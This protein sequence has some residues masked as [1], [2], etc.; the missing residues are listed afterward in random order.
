MRY[1]SVEWNLPGAT[2]PEHFERCREAP[3]R[4]PDAAMNDSAVNSLS[5]GP[6]DATVETDVDGKSNSGVQTRPKVEFIAGARPHLASETTSILR[7]RL[8][9]AAVMLLI[10]T[11][12]FLARTLLSS[13]PTVVGGSF[14]IGYRVFVLIMLLLANALLWSKLKLNLS[15]LRAIELA[16]FGL[17]CVLFLLLNYGMLL[18]LGDDFRPATTGDVLTPDRIRL[19]V[20]STTFMWFAMVIIYGTFIPNTVR[21]AAGVI[22]T[23]CLAPLAVII[24]TG[25]E[26]D[27]VGRIVFPDNLSVATAG[28]SFAFITALYGSYKVSSLRREA[29]EARRLGQY[30][31]TERLGAG[32]MGEVYLAEHQLLKRPCAIKLIRAVDAANAKALARFEREVRAIARLT[33]WNSVEIFD[34]GQTDDGTFYYAMEYLPGLSLQEVIER[35]GPLQPARAVHLLRQVCQA[36]NEAHT[37]GLIH[38]DIKPSNIIASQR[39]GVCDVAKLVDFGLATSVED[40]QEVKLTQEG[41]IAG[42]PFYIAPERFLEDD[43]PDARSDIY[44]L[45]GVAYFLLTGQPPF[46]GDVPLQIMIAHAREPVVPPRQIVADVPQDLEEIIVKCLAKEPHQRYADAAALEKALSECACADCWSQE[47]AAK[48]WVAR[49]ESAGVDTQADLPTTT[50]S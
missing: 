20:L 28:M 23:M 41:T 46:R 37:A 29:F 11:L 26:N 19:A 16:V 10:P 4:G 17:P 42:S 44:S 13:D 34:Y 6:L 27:D 25:L 1:D 50:L 5:G 33:H 45:G 2:A 9:I 38:R 21:R 35:Q 47:L 32:G 39:G 7:A 31:L 48:W 40:F 18:G 15:E 24:L 12:F 22:G 14:I 8:R 49:P 3:Q 30:R 43:E 36:L